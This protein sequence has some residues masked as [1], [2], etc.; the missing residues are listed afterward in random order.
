MSLL[1]NIVPY[2]G[3]MAFPAPLQLEDWPQHW[4]DQVREER[5]GCHPAIHTCAGGGW[6]LS[7][8]STL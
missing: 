8:E 7:V 4:D 1:G 6:G 5:E 2:R 3:T